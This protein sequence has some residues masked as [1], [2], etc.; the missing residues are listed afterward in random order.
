M[1]LTIAELAELPLSAALVDG[2][3]VVARTPEWRG[4]APGAVGYRV[5]RNRLVVSTD[6]AHPMCATVVDRLLD[7][8]DAT[9]ASLPRRQALRATM[10]AASL[11][12]VAG[13][14]VPDSGTSTDVLEHACAGIA[15]RTALTVMIEEHEPFAVLAP[16][17]AALVLVQ[18]AANAERHDHA[19]SVTLRGTGHTFTVSWQ[20][21]PGSPGIATARRRAERERWGLGF[22]RIA[23]D[24]IGGVLY[25]PVEDRDGMRCAVLEVG[26][27]HLALPLA[28]ISDGAVRKATR[29]WDEETSLHAGSVVAA[30][31][32]AGRCAAA[33]AS[34]PGVIA[35]VDGWTART[36]RRGVWVAVPPDTI[37]DRARDVLDGMVH[38]RALWDGVP[39]PGRSRIVA[40]AAILAAMLGADLVR[41]P[42]ETWNRRARQVA[43]AYGLGMTVPHFNGLGA[44]DPRVALFLA[45]EYGEE[46]EVDGDD[47]YLRIAENRGEDPLLR[48]FLSPGDNSL[49]L[50]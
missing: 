7:E 12:I 25:P 18:F 17:A 13:R 34:A 43:D 21:W 8:I 45:A 42:G 36:G 39:E 15:S 10:L 19:E 37:V 20:G 33:A 22:A 28:L 48:V 44:V 35:H 32:R 47:L 23:A 41:V 3:E 6:D 26:L 9:T 49:K 16:A 30:E 24:S 40:L 50:S 11:R 27:N 4:A 14:A 1:N 5:R 38:E 31:G 2:E 29:A 46:L